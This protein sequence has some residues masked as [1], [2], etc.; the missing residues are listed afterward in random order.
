MEKNSLS[1]LLEAGGKTSTGIA[2]LRLYTPQEKQKRAWKAFFLFV[3]LGI[4]SIILPLAHFFLVPGFI[5]ASPFAYRWAKNQVGTVIS[6]EG[7]CP[8]CQ[9]PIVHRGGAIQWP[10][11]INCEACREP[12]KAEPINTANE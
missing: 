11:R 9:K 3:G 2:H 6:L 1:I 12:V 10:L 4:V 8:F 5:L 7:I